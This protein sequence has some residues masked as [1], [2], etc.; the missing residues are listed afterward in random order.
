MDRALATRT[1][2]DEL[3]AR[4][5]SAIEQ[6]LDSRLLQS[7]IT[8]ST[9]MSIGTLACLLLVARANSLPP[10]CTLPSQIRTALINFTRQIHSDCDSQEQRDGDQG[11]DESRDS[12][13]S[14]SN[15]NNIDKQVCGKVSSEIMKA[16]DERGS[17]KTG[18]YKGQKTG[19]CLIPQQSTNPHKDLTRFCDEDWNDD[20]GCRHTGFPQ[21]LLLPIEEKQGHQ[22]PPVLFQLYTETLKA[23]C[24]EGTS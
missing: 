10:A 9:F 6:Q 12:E 21:Y 13:S 22:M 15:G 8:I 20:K 11:D 7:S 1:V 19:S 2:V 3:K 16:S 14:T 5:T 17:F 23:V 24:S 18:D 4:L